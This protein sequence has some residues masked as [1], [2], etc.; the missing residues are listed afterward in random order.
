MMNSLDESKSTDEIKRWM[1]FAEIY[2]HCL[3][4]DVKLQK[5]QG[6]NRYELSTTVAKWF[7]D[8]N[9]L[10]QIYATLCTS[11]DEG[12]VVDDRLQKEA[13]ILGFHLDT[14]YSMAIHVYDRLGSENGESN[15]VVFL[16]DGTTNTP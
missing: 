5:S 3:K 6:C 14:I 11:S 9:R 7:P 8:G 1:R 12:T 15:E 2:L 10:R 4:S 13:D 16:F